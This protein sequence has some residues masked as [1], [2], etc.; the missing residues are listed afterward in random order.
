[1]KAKFKVFPVTYRG[2][3]EPTLEEAIN[4]FL[5]E[6]EGNLVDVKMEIAVDNSPEPYCAYIDLFVVVIYEPNIKKGGK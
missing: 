2:E 1:M 6:I 4:K 3:N 5:E